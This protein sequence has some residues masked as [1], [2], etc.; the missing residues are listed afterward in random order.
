MYIYEIE[1]QRRLTILESC[2]VGNSISNEQKRESFSF[3]S[4]NSQTLHAHATARIIYNWPG[5]RVERKLRSS[6]TE[7]SKKGK[8]SRLQEMKI[9][10][11]LS[12]SRHCWSIHIQTMSTSRIFYIPVLTFLSFIFTTGSILIS[13]GHVNESC[14]MH[15]ALSQT[16]VRFIY[17]STDEKTL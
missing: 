5:A 12:Q 13:L 8:K 3:P 15:T 17:T 6:F 11:D 9:R 14:G 1:S 16:P 4:R 7:A 10:K 2:R